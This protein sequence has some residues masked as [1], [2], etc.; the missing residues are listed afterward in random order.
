MP[1]RPRV[2]QVLQPEDGGVA[3]HVL[4]LSLGL[5]ERGFEVEVALSEA[6]TVAPE[7]RRAGTRLHGLALEREVGVHDARGAWALRRLARG[8]RYDL[9][10]AHS[11]K[12][13]A[14]ARLALPRRPPVL[15]TPHCFAFATD[16]PG[17]APRVY[18][19]IE[20]ALLP[21]TDALIAVA[22][23]ERRLAEE[24]LGARPGTVRLI[25]N[26]VRPCPRVEP[27]P[28]LVEFRGDGPLA[29]M[30]TALRPQKDPLAAVRAAAL[31][32]PAGER[33]P[34]LAVVGNGE[35]RPD[36]ERLIEALGVGDR[37]R[38]FPFEPP[39]ARYLLALDAFV[40]P[41]RW[42]ALPLSIA[43]AMR[44]GVPVVATTVGGVPEMVDDGMTG[45]LV[46]P[47]H[48]LDLARAIDD[49]LA[50]EARRRSMSEAARAVAEERFGVDRMV[51]ETA[52]LYRELLGRPPVRR[53]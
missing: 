39:A 37:V 15:Y 30:V 49:V 16:Q 34:R 26:G 14:L 7:L 42:E 23:W 28:E 46:R 11:S 35:L 18:R 43:E 21:R 25:R 12:A 47:G 19:T 13:G 24:E 48:A 51:E 36:V 32:R 17:R 10:H 52:A 41:A 31:L 6:S 29:G 8:G 20:R 44:C 4:L 3:E 50:E 1:S 9:V 53:R 38:W 2:L 22:E 40:L 33:R 5:L 27:A 45:R